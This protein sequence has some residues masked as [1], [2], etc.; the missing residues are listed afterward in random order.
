MS[1]VEASIIR[2]YLQGQAD[3]LILDGATHTF[4]LDPGALRLSTESGCYPAHTIRS[5][6]Y[7]AADVQRVETDWAMTTTGPA[8]V[9]TQVEYEQVHGPCDKAGGATYADVTGLDQP[10]G[11]QHIPTGP[12]P[13]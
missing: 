4:E 6:F 10:P 8:R 2:V 11:T 1:S 3:P 9:L 7:P 12:A 5:V 13:R